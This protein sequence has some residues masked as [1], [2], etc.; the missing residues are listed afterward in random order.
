VEAA[1]GTFKPGDW[2]LTAEVFAPGER[3]G[4]E[5]FLARRPCKLAAIYHDSIP[6]C[7]PHITWPKAVARHPAYLTMLSQFDRV[8]AISAASRDE[9]LGFWRWQGRTHF[10]EVSVLALGSDLG[11]GQLPADPERSRGA[12]TRPNSS[13]NQ[14]DSRS[15]PRLLCVGILEPR[16]NQ[17]FL[18]Q[19][20]DRLWRESLEFELHF[21][22]RIN[23]HFGKPIV[24]EIRAMQAKRPGLFYHGAVSD[25]RLQ[26][27]YAGAAAC[28]FPTIAEGCGLPLL[29]ALRHGTP[30]IAS[31]LPSMRENA[32][33]GGC[34]MLPASGI[35]AW[36]AALREF[37]SEPSC[38]QGLVQSALLRSSTLPT[39]SQAALALQSALTSS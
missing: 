31:D 11:G 23:P 5:A 10:P 20:A 7:L 3:R 12:G 34:W 16:K 2:Y 18:L 33:G 25:E 22:G 35:E 19:V 8:W 39:W 4:F 26:R 37:L 24:A 36:T 27:L 14:A 21:V 1:A 28:V 30:C 15:A 29:E 13:A 17:S 6:L 38:R 9:L 32:Q